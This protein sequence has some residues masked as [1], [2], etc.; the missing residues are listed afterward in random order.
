MKRILDFLFSFIILL[1]ITWFL[2][3]C[4]IIT[5]IETKSFGMF[6]QKRIGQFGKPFMIYKLKTMHSNSE[7]ITFFGSFFRKYKIDELPQFFNVLIGN[8]SIVGPRPDIEGYYDKL[9]GED[10]KILEL[11]PGITSLAS[12]KYRNEDEILEKQDYPLEYNDTIIFPDKVK[13]NL[14]YYNHQSF[15]VD[16][17]IIVQTI[18]SYL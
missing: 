16:I 13:M 8:M 9:V 7:K 14:E 3:I 17:K 1:F 10:R 6:F 5:S 2:I 18:K 11:K 15:L 4:L 12:I